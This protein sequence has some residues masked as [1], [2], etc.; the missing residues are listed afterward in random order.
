MS[1]MRPTVLAAGVAV[2]AALAAGT[3]P[4]QQQADLEFFEKRV[5]PVLAQRCQECHSVASGKE[6]GGLRLD[7]RQ[8][9]LDGGDSGPAIVAGNAA[10][11]LLL[12][13]VRYEDPDLQMPPKGMLTEQEVEDLEHWVA[14]GAHWPEERQ[15]AAGAVRPGTFDLQARRASHWAWQP[16]AVHPVPEVRDRTWPAGDVDRFL[17]ARIEAAGLPTAAEADRA[18]LLRRASFVLTGLPP[19]VA[20][21]R[22][23]EA[24]TAP[25]AWERVVDRLLASPHYGE[26]WARHWLDL[27]RYSETLGH[28]FDFTLHHAWRYRDYLVRAFNDDLPYDQFVR[29]HVAGDL[30]DAPR[31]DPASGADESTVATTFWWLGQRSHSPVDVRAS[32]A[33]YVENQIDVMGK[34]FLGLTI[35]CARCHDH[36][37]DAISTQDYYAL[38]GVMSS[39]RSRMVPM[40]PPSTWQRH[41]EAVAAARDRLVDVAV[42]RLAAAA[43]QLDRHLLAAE[44]IVAEQ[45]LHGSAPATLRMDGR[46]GDLDP[47]L[48]RRWVELLQ[49]DAVRRGGHPMHAFHLVSQAMP[50]DQ[51]RTWD[52]VRAHR[53]PKATEGTDRELLGDFRTGDLQGWTPTGAG[54]HRA[55]AGTALAGEKPEDPV[56]SFA[57]GACMH[58]GTAGRRLQSALRSP[59]RVVSRRYLHVRVAGRSARVNAVVDGFQ[60]IRYP[61]YG[62]L[63]RFV[64]HPE[65]RWVTFDLERWRGRKL[66]V[67]LLDQ[68]TPDFADEVR[69]NGYGP[70]SWVAVQQ[71]WLSD[72]ARPPAT[73]SPGLA[74]SVHVDGARVS[75]TEAL[76]AGLRET[77]LRSLAMVADG[78]MAYAK[79][80]P[81]RIALLNLLV[82]RR[83]L[84]LDNDPELAAAREEAALAAAAVPAPQYVLGA[85]DGSGFDEPVFVRG[86]HKVTGPEVRRGFL[87]ALS[88]GPRET[89]AA[90]SGRRELAAAITDP[91]NPL[92]ARVMANR[93]WHHV[94]GRGL[95][96]SVDD[97]GALGEAPSHP[98]LLDWLALRFVH[99]G[100]SV[101]A[102][103]RE[104]ILS[105]AFRASSSPADASVATTDPDNRLLSHMRMRRV[106]GEALRD[107]LLR[108]SGRLDPTM[109]GPP[110]GV[111][112]TAFMSGR[113]RPGSGPLDGN[114]RRSLYVEVRRNFL[115]PMMLAFDV[116]MPS[117]TVGRRTVSNVPAQALILMND[118]F[119]LQQARHWA[120]RVLAE[121][122]EDD[123]ERLALVHREALAR[124]PRAEELDAM[125]SFVREQERAHAGAEDAAA[126]R[127]L[128]WTDLCHVVCNLKEFVFVP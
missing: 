92:T 31:R 94:F 59:T 12:R 85:E 10:A 113:G 63:K 82:G 125:E 47:E 118:P 9:L 80:A 8:A 104:L 28:E 3:A 72:E 126:R 66:H 106:E 2:A 77:A 128:A 19:T 76:A 18:T 105:R 73:D 38:Y 127:L 112:L 69:E 42:P 58:S 96:P 89:V 49:S 79:D 120:T 122:H 41:H 17:L 43:A 87:E 62:E 83:L 99:D 71:A 16:M 5:R 75:T 15:P 1:R 22:A 11:S 13:A 35:A 33:E 111:H 48:L 91:A 30:L 46:A 44:R 50:A 119:V 24:D 68:E 52:R 124:E 61:I 29:E 117:T 39:T 101:K 93:V 55:H 74:W 84:P 14:S 25:G 56:L 60:L 54:F 34:A 27:V 123:R 65:L 64:D 116:P 23:F 95:V 107:S 57:D 32:E 98:E 81:A 97:F 21:V 36:K 121:P 7:S 115:P 6:K 114:G 110:V 108:V 67:E 4:G 51:G 100:W 88:N 20:E 90:G 102:L 45:S 37:F 103:V 40:Q 26:R 109:Y 86:N 53:A 78:S 70:D